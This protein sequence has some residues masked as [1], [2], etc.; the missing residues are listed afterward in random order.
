MSKLAP[1]EIYELA[2]LIAAR[3]GP[4]RIAKESSGWH[5]YFPSPIALE[6]DGL[7]ELKR[8][9]MHGAINAEK[10][11]GLGVYAANAGT[12]ANDRCAQC[13]KY[14]K[15]YTIAQLLQMEPLADRGY[16]NI[17]SSV[18]EK[19]EARMEVDDNG[20]KIPISPGTFKPLI[21][22]RPDHHV[23]EFLKSRRLD[24]RTMQ[25]F[26]PVAYCESEFPEDRKIGPYYPRF[27]GGFKSTPQGRLILFA[28]IKGVRKTWQARLL[29]KTVDGVVHFWHPYD[30]VWTAVGRKNP[31][32]KKLETFPEF[33]STSEWEGDL[34]KIHKYTM[35]AGTERNSILLGF[36]SAVRFKAKHGTRTC[37]VVEGPLKAIRVR[38]PCVATLGKYVSPNQAR[39][40]ASEF[41]DIVGI[42]DNDDAGDGFVEKLFGNLAEYGRMPRILRLRADV[43]D[44][45]EL[46]Q[47]EA[48]ALFR[49][50]I[51]F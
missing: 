49:K 46:D 15:A 27:G 16:K 44:A 10:F 42:P 36:D 45:D 50:E 29:E 11:L 41:D 38:P 14:E 25:E 12:G 22:L 19:P 39:L 4:T 40:L 47:E 31:E 6:K 9:N 18:F 51:R 8:S 5:I 3:H 28:M 37:F 32:T 13:M 43:K 26:C 17:E 24:V 23:F 34:H 1:P 48:D 30:K 33:S 2:E 35:P 7:V 21:A 20:N